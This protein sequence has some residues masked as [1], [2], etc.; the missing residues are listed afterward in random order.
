MEQAAHATSRFRSRGAAM[1]AVCR[2]G[3]RRT[4]SGLDIRHIPFNLMVSADNW[5]WQTNPFMRSESG[6]KACGC[7]CPSTACEAGECVPSGLEKTWAFH[8][9]CDHMRIN[10]RPPGQFIFLDET[11]AFSAPL[12]PSQRRRRV[13]VAVPPPC[14][15]N[16]GYALED[17]ALGRADPYQAATDFSTMRAAPIC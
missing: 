11:V 4:G 9:R 17:R 1:P 3:R 14:S 13:V 12:P 16:T 6:R 10:A 15:S 5:L 8:C 2:S 7:K